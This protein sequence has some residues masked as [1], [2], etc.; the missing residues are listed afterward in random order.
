MDDAPL[1]EQIAASTEDVRALLDGNHRLSVALLARLQREHETD[2]R[3]RFRKLDR[4]R[5][6]R[7]SSLED[8]VD[9][10]SKRLDLAKLKFREMREELDILKEKKAE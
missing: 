9:K 2:V 5:E 3:E 4:S 1:A 7:T 8:A 10:L 6:N